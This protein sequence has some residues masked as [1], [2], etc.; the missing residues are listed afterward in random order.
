M[1]VLPERI[2]LP[3]DGSGDAIRATDAASDLAKE[4]GAELHVV[5][6]WHDVRGFAHDFVKRELRRQGQEILDEQVEK[7]RASGGEVTKAYLRRGRT[8][9]EVIALCKEI[10]AGL[11]VVGSRGLGTVRR[12]LMGSQSEE[13]VHHA[14]VPVLVLTGAENFWPPARIVV[15]E[16]FSDDARKAG[17]LAAGIGKLY[18]AK[19]LL[20]YSHPDLPEVPPGEARSAVQHLTEMRERDKSM[21][22]DR[23]GD[24]EKI[25]GNRPEIKIS[26]GYPA[27]VL[28]EASQEMQPSI[29]AVGSRGLAGLIRTRLGSV[30]T[31]VVTAAR[32]P[33]LVYPHVD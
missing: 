29:V 27:N 7:I 12:I 25:L 33:V 8:S 28:L 6:V 11:L 23:A 21:L 20:V 19:G 32:G 9:N 22:E 3:T 16:D 4:S 1:S 2:L 30:S 26:G 5:H 18:D 24:L 13:I 31:K 10:D 17:E 14:Q 15:G